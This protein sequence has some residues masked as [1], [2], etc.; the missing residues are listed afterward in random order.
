[1]FYTGWTWSGLKCWFPNQLVPH[2][3]K[4]HPVNAAHRITYLEQPI[5]SRSWPTYGYAGVH[6]LNLG[7]ECPLKDGV[8]IALKS[9]MEKHSF[10]LIACI[11]ES[12][13]CFNQIW[14][15]M[16][17]SHSFFSSAFA[18]AMTDL[19]PKIRSLVH[20]ISAMHRHF[21]FLVLMRRLAPDRCSTNIYIR[22]T[23]IYTNV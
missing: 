4:F 5:I 1:M 16:R 23:N 19:V 13:I 21:P 10:P 14:T 20:T 17:C 15:R 12:C 9:A 18:T 6:T 8:K 22:Y 3:M 2:G 11:K 7:R